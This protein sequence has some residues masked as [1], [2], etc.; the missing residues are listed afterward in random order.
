[1]SLTVQQEPQSAQTGHTRP[2]SAIL[3]SLRN[4]A[5]LTQELLAEK[6]GIELALVKAIEESHFSPSLEMLEKLAKALTIN[7]RDLFPITADTDRGVKFQFKKGRYTRTIW[8]KGKPYYVYEDLIT[9]TENVSLRPEILTLL[10]TREEER[11]LNEGHFL[12]QCTYALHG[13]LRFYWKF[14]DKVYSQDFEEGDSWYIRPFVPHSFISLDPNDLAKIIAF[15]FG[16]N[17]TPDAVNELAVIGKEG[18][19]RIVEEDR[20]WFKA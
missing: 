5:K 1:M 18:A 20:Q 17:I 8:R 7:L 10:C 4:D 14:E 19:C 12:H 9:T 11:V 15:T 16:G 3:R 2:L 6:S 13:K